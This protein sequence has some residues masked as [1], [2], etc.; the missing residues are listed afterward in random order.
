MIPEAV[1]QEVVL[2]GKGRP[3]EE[4]VKQ[5]DWILQE[6]VTSAGISNLMLD[7]LDAGERE[8]IALAYDFKADYVILDER[9]ARRRANLLG[10]TVIGT[11]ASC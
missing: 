5:A 7:K 3:G 1:Y 2:F 11:L 8:S 6:Q 10:L 4:E 9:L